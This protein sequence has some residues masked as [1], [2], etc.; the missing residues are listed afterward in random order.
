M[1]TYKW[2]NLNL[3]T[4]LRIRT[5]VNHRPIKWLLFR[6]VTERN[7]CFSSFSFVRSP[8]RSFSRFFCQ[9][10]FCTR[11][12]FATS[13]SSLLSFTL[14][15]ANKNSS[16]RSTIFNFPLSDFPFLHMNCEVLCACRC[17]FGWQILWIWTITHVNVNITARNVYN[18]TDT[19]D[20]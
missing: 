19:Y 7:V 4:F 3:S 14:Q 20:G 5:Y 2:Q 15:S 6:T 12:S 11:F 13:L 1:T 9:F 17:L 16:I 18:S 10:L 8:N